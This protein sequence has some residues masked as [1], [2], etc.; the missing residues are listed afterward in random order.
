MHRLILDASVIISW[1]D[2]LGDLVVLESILD[3]GFT[4]VT[5]E[6]VMNEVLSDGPLLD[7]VEAESEIIRTD[8]VR[9]E[10]LSNRYLG[11][12]SGEVSVLV[13]GERYESN[14]T[15]YSCVLDDGRARKVCGRLNLELTGSIG[16]FRELVEQDVM[17]LEKA[18]SVVQE[19]KANGT[20]LPENHRELI[21][22]TPVS[23]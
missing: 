8:P 7:R 2:E 1:C 14:G 11:L 22:P 10:E 3:A 18:D 12:G 16:V 5:T 23:D 9:R 17:E 15:K 13:L 21:Q 6:T 20:R 19:M 4:P